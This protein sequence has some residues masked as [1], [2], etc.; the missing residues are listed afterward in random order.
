MSVYDFRPVS[1]GDLPLIESWIKTPAVKEWWIEADGEPADPIGEDELDDPDI[2]MWIVSYR[3]TPFAF[4]QDYDPHAWPGHHFRDLPPRSRG[5]DQFI[6]IP[7][8]LG[9]GHGSAFIKA[10]VDRLLANGVPVVGTDPHPSNL[11]AI[12]AYEKAGFRSKAEKTTEWGRCLLME[13]QAEPAA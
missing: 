6:G 11:R 12:R 10:H 3:S 9:C 1:N 13:R 5:I 4:I 7:E 8:M 2:A